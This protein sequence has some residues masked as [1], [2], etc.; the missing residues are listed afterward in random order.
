MLF[1]SEAFRSIIPFFFDEVKANRIESRHDPNNPHSGDVMKKC[2]LKYEG[3]LR[4][5]DWNNQGIVDT[6]MYGLLREEWNLSK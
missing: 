6:C 3:T 5:A 1:R 4:Q 2:G